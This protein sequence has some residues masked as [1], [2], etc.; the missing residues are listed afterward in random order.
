MLVWER[1]EHIVTGD[2]R[3]HWLD[4]WS[5]FGRR[6]RCEEIIWSI[7][8]LNI[9]LE[10]KDQIVHLCNTQPDFTPHESLS[11]G[12]TIRE[13]PPSHPCNSLLD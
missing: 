7:R 6:A 12:E 8:E 13:S 11:H 2:R 9:N 10:D 5:S 3:S 1:R 4:E